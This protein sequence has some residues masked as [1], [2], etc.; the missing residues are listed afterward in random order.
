MSWPEIK[1]REGVRKVKEVFSGLGLLTKIV[2]LYTVIV[3][4]FRK[5]YNFY[6]PSTKFLLKE[7]N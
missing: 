3:A 1:F 4:L 2:T 6:L 5:F 7:K